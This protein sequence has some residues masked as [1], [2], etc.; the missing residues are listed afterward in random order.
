MSTRKATKKD[1]VI[2]TVIAGAVSAACMAGMKLINNK[3]KKD[4]NN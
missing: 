2:G 3:M 4:K 1:F